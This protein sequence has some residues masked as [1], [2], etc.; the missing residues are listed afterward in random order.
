[1]LVWVVLCV[2]DGHEQVTAYDR[3]TLHPNEENDKNYTSFMFKF[4]DH[5][6]GC[7][8]KLLRQ[9]ICQILNI[10]SNRVLGCYQILTTFLH[11]TQEKLPEQENAMFLFT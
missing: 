11:I 3:W 8:E 4:K 10:Q 1:M 9:I 5:S 7:K 2:N 6:R